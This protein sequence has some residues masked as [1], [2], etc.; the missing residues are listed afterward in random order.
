MFTL[1]KVGVIMFLKYSHMMLPGLFTNRI[2]T[3]I[4]FIDE[5]VVECDVLLVKILL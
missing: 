5:A 4:D 2:T 3:D 1:F